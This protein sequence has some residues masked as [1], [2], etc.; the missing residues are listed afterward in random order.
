MCSTAETPQVT[1]L[2]LVCE[3]SQSLGTVSSHF[4]FI[5]GLFNNAVIRPDYIEKKVQLLVHN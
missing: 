4:I 1:R 5:C 2:Y 3:L